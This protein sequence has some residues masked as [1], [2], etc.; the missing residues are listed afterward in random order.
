MLSGTPPFYGKNNKDILKSVL[1]GVYTFN[2]QPFKVC[3][4]E[5]KDLITKL[6][7]RTPEKRYSALNAYNHPWV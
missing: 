7:V 1:K 6:L 3:S 4:D 2:L 5:V